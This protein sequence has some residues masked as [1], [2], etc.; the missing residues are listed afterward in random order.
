MQFNSD[1]GI[2][3]YTSSAQCCV[4]RRLA[5]NQY[6][7]CEVGML[8]FADSSDNTTCQFVCLHCMHLGIYSIFCRYLD[9]VYILV[10]HENY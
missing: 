7:Y 6:T 3:D 5:I 2:T 10:K 9:L 1:T 4:V 8:K